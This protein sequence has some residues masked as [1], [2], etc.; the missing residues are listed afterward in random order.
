M[1]ALADTVFYNSLA[2]AI[3]GSARFENTVASFIHT[4]F[5]NP[6]TY[7]LPNL[8]Y[9]QMLRGPTGQ[10]GSHTGLLYVLLVSLFETI[11]MNVIR[12]LKCMAKIATGLMILREGKSTAWTSDLDTQMNNWTNSYIQWVETADLALQEKASVKYATPYF[13]ISMVTDMFHSNHG[14][15]YFN[16]LAALKLIVGD[17]AGAKSTIQEYFQGIYQNQITAT[18]EQPFEA[19]R[20]HPYHYRAYNLAAMIVSHS[21][22]NKL[23]FP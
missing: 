13:H 20:T 12:D 4:W 19:E 21:S 6:D 14:S 10:K 9:A 15:Y 23:K 5:L 7:M 11:L 1:N 17:T 8:D 22:P 3:N 2:W 16:Q 18:G